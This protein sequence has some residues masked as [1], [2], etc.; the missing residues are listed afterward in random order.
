MIMSVTDGFD[1]VVTLAREVAELRERQAQLEIERVAIEEQITDR[2]NRIA[3]AAVATV[4]PATSEQVAQPADASQP[5][6]LSAAI[7][8][9]I[10]QH[11]DK[12]FTPVEIAELLNMSDDRSYSNIRTHLSRMAGNGR[13]VRPEF[14]K[15]KAR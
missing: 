7:L 9:T 8:F 5:M 13:V 1:L 10:R 15:Y 6:T 3:A 12:E 11:P 14:G 4:T 2:V